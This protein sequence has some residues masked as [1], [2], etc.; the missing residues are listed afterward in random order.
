[1]EPSRKPKFSFSLENILFWKFCGLVFLLPI[2]FIPGLSMPLLSIKYGL[3]VL[4]VV[5]VVIIWILLRLKDGVCLLPI[6]MLNLSLNF[7]S[8]VTYS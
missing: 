1:M 5:A 6:N 4:A 2:I 7:K 8:I 3:L